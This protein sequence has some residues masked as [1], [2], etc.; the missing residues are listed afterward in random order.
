MGS[1]PL[2][3]QWTI[4]LPAR[5]SSVSQGAVPRKEV[6]RQDVKVTKT[7]TI[8]T[9]GLYYTA[10]CFDWQERCGEH[11]AK[12]LN[13][14]RG[15]I[16]QARYRYHGFNPGSAETCCIRWREA[17]SCY[18]ERNSGRGSMGRRDYE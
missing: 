3:E 6:R 11:T 14:A 9:G 15:R 4:R 5:L 16:P 18:D 1:I 17:R 2:G 7:T 13:C 10:L 12:A 8:S